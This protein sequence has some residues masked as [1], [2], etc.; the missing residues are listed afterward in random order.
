MKKSNCDQLY[1]LC[2]YVV[3]IIMSSLLF[4]LHDKTVVADEE[5]PVSAF[6]DSVFREYCLECFDADADG[7]LTQSEADSVLSLKLWSEETGEITSVKGIEY[8]KN[9]N[10]L[11]IASCQV[12]D[13]SYIQGLS[14]LTEL[15][16]RNLQTDVDYS[17]IGELTA[18]TLLEIE[19]SNVKD[20]SFLS[21]LKKVTELYL[22]YNE[23]IMDYTPLQYTTNVQY[24]ELTGAGTNLTDISMLRDYKALKSISIETTAVSSL[25][26]L[27]GSEECMK[28]LYASDA[29]ITDIEILKDFLQLQRIELNGNLLT[30]IPDLTDLT[31]LSG[32]Q[33]GGNPLTVE[34]LNGL[35]NLLPDSIT[36][37]TDWQASVLDTDQ[38]NRMNGVIEDTS[39]QEFN[40]EE[41]TTSPE[42]D[43]PN[44]KVLGDVLGSGATVCGD[45]NDGVYFESLRIHNLE[46]QPK[47]VAYVQSRVKY[48]QDLQIY[49]MGLYKEQLENGIRV[50]VQP[51]GTVEVSVPIEYAEGMTGRVWHQK[52]DGSFRELP[53]FL[54]DGEIHFYTDR[55]SIFVLVITKLFGG[56]SSGEDGDSVVETGSGNLS[57]PV[58]AELQNSSEMQTGNGTE[59][60]ENDTEESVDDAISKENNVEYE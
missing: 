42:E 22:R 24:L 48:I 59:K 31:Q 52:E 40:T 41:T 7:E 11:S 32:I 19:Y 15:R 2:K 27:S 51:N 56:E 25:D 17:V 37:L 8:F 18:L 26:G 5:I 60:K 9:L 13:L 30:S 46:S 12:R 36:H 49:D 57:V 21:S 3:S 20:V 29:Q 14:D 39:E 1:N 55:F 45:I 10:E 58:D 53:T 34:I 38:I 6:E 4:F 16:I 28:M 47:A 43:S 54:K 50:K 23:N 33:L 44:Y 35:E